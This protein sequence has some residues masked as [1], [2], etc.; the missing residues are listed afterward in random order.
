MRFITGIDGAQC[1]N[2]GDFRFEDLI[3]AAVLCAVLL[4][5]VSFLRRRIKRG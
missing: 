5:A 2:C 1:S 4:L 3:T